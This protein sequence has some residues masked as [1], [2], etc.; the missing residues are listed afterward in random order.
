MMTHLSKAITLGLAAFAVAAC[1]S[2]SS[3]D[4][5]RETP[6]PE[7]PEGCSETRLWIR[8]T[9][10]SECVVAF[11]GCVPESTDTRVWMQFASVVEC[12]AIT[13]KPG[14]VRAAGDG[15]NTCSC[16]S[17]SATNLGRG[18]WTCTNDACGAAVPTGEA[19]G[20]FEGSCN[21]G[22]YCAFSPAE[23]CSSLDAPSI[24]I[25]QPSECTSED[26]PVCGC[27]GTTYTNR[28]EAA[29]AGT[30]IRDMG[31]CPRTGDPIACG[32]RAGDTCSADEFCAYAVGDRCGESDVEA[33]CKPRPAECIGVDA[34]VCGCDGQTYAN[35]CEAAK[36]GTGMLSEGACCSK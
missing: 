28:C 6:A 7:P 17:S 20:F 26:V 29:R 5:C 12:Q 8:T 1:G 23:A 36:A 34:P 25:T 30:G 15:C 3:D 18:Y 16:R 9:Q 22:E 32:G 13:C 35:A 21:A 27:N 10:S 14:D 4:A 33:T 24:C 19:C 31:P 11:A 2:T